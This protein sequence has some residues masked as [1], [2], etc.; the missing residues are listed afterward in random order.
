MNGD[1]DDY[2]IVGQSYTAT[3]VQIHGG[4]DCAYY[5]DNVTIR[6]SFCSLGPDTN[7]DGWADSTGFCDPNG[8]HFDGF[9]SDGGSHQVYDHNT[10]RNPCSQTSAILISTNSSP[11][12]DVTITDNLL[13]GG[14][15]TL[16]CDAGPNVTGGEVVTGNR[17]ART[18]WPDGGW[19]GPLANCGGS[20]MT[21]AGNVW[22]DTGAPVG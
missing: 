17:I 14:G 15:Y 6:D 9:S 12:S 18:F 2:G 22:D 11:I 19:Y 3:R 13:A 10:I 16:Y 1:V 7:D 20:S 5:E 8:P 21:F 4:A